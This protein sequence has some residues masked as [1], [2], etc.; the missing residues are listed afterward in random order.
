L[1]KKFD[2]IISNSNIGNAD[3]EFEVGNQLIV[4]TYTQSSRIYVAAYNY[5]TDTVITR[6]QL[7]NSY[8][9][10]ICYNDGKFYV[11]QSGYLYI[12]NETAEGLVQDGDAIITPYLPSTPSGIVGNLPK[13]PNT[14]NYANGLIFITTKDNVMLYIFDVETKK[15]VSVGLRYKAPNGYSSTSLTR[16]TTYNKYF[17]LPIENALLMITKSHNI[18]Y[19]MGYKYTNNLIITNARYTEGFEYDNRFVSF[20]DAYMSIHCGNITKEMIPFEDGSLIKKATINKEEYK[21][22]ISLKTYEMNP[23]S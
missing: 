7:N 18:K 9:A 13:E 21:Q 4:R 1:K 15:F 12:Y 16:P 14:M 11:S 20:K 2:K 22:M 6:I 19:N 5:I 23:D 3:Y 10:R 17:F 8:S